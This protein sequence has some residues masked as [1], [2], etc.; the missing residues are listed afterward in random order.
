M[1]GDAVYFHRRA[2]EEHDRAMAA[3]HPAARQAHLEL[4]ARYEELASAIVSHAGR[5]LGSGDDEIAA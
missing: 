3:A 2:S 5:T 1:E 4:S